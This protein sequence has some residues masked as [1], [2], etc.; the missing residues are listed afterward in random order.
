MT[1]PV[2]QELEESAAPTGCP[3]HA[4]KAADGVSRRGFL[5][6]LGAAGAMAPGVCM[7]GASSAAHAQTAATTIR[8][9]RFGRIFRLPPFATPSPQLTAA[10][11]ELGK[12]GGIMD[13]KDPL[14]QGPIL[15]ITDP[16]LERQQSEQHHA[17]RRHDVLRPVRRS[18]RHVRPGL[19]AR[20]A[21][22]AGGFDEHALAG[23]GPRLRVRRW[24]GAQPAAVR[25][26]HARASRSA[27]SSCASSTADCSK[28]C[29]ARRTARRSSA[30]RATTS[31]SSLPVCTRRS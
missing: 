22:A 11:T 20:R 10:L 5:G 15:L 25:P 1:T 29:R 31:T 18:R 2:N 8:E 16:A 17:D 19:D 12:V 28:I 26:A 21:D 27:G 13:A 9:D 3:M 7:M 6:A 30:I 24:T 23:A 4:K 14:E